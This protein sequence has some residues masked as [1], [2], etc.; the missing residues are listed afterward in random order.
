MYLNDGEVP[1]DNNVT[2]GA[3]RSFCLHKHAWKLTDSINGA[4][5]SAIIYSITKTA[6]MNNLNSFRYSTYILTVLKDHQDDTDYGFIDELLPWSEQLPEIYRSKSK[7]TN[8]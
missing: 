7:T 4:K 5:S 6:K 1:P 2:E 3:F 8:V